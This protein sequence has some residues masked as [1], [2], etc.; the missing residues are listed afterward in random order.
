MIYYRLAF[1]DRQTAK[2]TWKTTT[3][4]SLQSVFQ[5]LRA[6]S[7]LPQDSIRVFTASSIEGLNEMISSENNGLASGSVTATQFL[8]ERNLSVPERV[9]SASEQRPSTQAAR[10]GASVVTWAQELWEKHIMTGS[11]QA[12]RPGSSVAIS[13]PLG[14]PL[15]AA[16]ASAGLGMGLLEQKRL[17]IERGPGGDHDTPYVFTLPVSMPQ[18]L[19]WTRLQTRVQAGELAS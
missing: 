18:L 9:Q 5:L 12:S 14:E 2:W 13:S 10:P 16:G 15:I 7:A 8:Q 4:T 17:E 3:L 19:A 11:A 6:F 1:Q